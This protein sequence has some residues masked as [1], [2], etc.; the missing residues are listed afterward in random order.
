MFQAS[1]CLAALGVSYALHAKHHPFVSAAAQA[2]AAAA[3]AASLKM[4][5]NGEVANQAAQREP[6]VDFNLMET[7]LLCACFVIILQ[8]NRAPGFVCVC[9]CVCV[10]GSAC[11]H[12]GRVVRCV[13][14]CASCHSSTCAHPRPCT[15]GRRAWYSRAL[16]SRQV[17]VGT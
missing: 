12:G 11:A 13:L 2:E 3:A 5:E 8:V 7:T 10:S 15:R 1:L 6:L 16:H 14:L 4:G 9:V 17:A